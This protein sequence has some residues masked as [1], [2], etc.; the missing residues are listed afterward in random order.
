VP[1]GVGASPSGAQV[2]GDHDVLDGP[3]SE[4]AEA[5]EVPAGDNSTLGFGNVLSRNCLSGAQSNGHAS[6]YFLQFFCDRSSAP[7]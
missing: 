1:E 4:P 5:V 2:C 3:V 6:P 7:P